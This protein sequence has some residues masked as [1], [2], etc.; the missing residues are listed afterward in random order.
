MESD[1]KSELVFDE[2]G[3]TADR[4]MSF[5]PHAAAGLVPGTG[6]GHR[7]SALA[8]VA[9]PRRRQSLTAGG[10]EV[11]VQPLQDPGAGHPGEGAAQAAHWQGQEVSIGEHQTASVVG[12][13]ISW[14]FLAVLSPP[15]ANLALQFGPW[16][17]FT[18]VLMALVMLASLSQGS[19][20]KGLIAAALGMILAMPGID[21]SI[22]QRRLTFGIDQLMGGLNLLPVLIGTFAISQMTAPAGI[23]KTTA[24]HKTKSVRSISEV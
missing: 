5:A 22:G 12:G 1:L 19:L 2:M 21:P 23:A 3:W 7:H 13:I 10:F 6:G 4:A 20:V 11:A 18:M 15:L 14:V 24:R 16:E 17:Y 8:A 9:E